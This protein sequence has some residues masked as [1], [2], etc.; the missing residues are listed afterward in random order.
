MG[1]LPLI[2]QSAV[3]RCSET[4]LAGGVV[5]HPRSELPWRVVTHVLAMST[6]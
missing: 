2:A 5:E 3:E 1:A 6:L 4:S